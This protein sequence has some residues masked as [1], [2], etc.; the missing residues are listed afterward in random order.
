MDST[1]T[2]IIIA[3]CAWGGQIA[4]GFLQLRSF[5]R[6]LQ[7]MSRLG[8][9]KI[10][11]TEGRWKPR[12]I[13]ILAEDKDRVVVGAKVMKGVSV[14]SRPKS[15]PEVIGKQYPF[16]SSVTNGFNNNVREAIEIA[17]SS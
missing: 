17:F 3:I 16:E 15:L 2:L 6:T 8:T 12:T 1:T 14:F 5:N 9:V 4:L 7:K 13:V 10:G 11:R